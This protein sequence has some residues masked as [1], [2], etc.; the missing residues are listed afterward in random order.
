[1]SK[2]RIDLKLIIYILLT[3]A[4]GLVMKYYRG[5][6]SGFFN[7]S[8]TGAVYVTFWCFIVRLVLN[9]LSAHIIAIMVTLITCL[10]EFGQLWQP[11]FLQ[12]LRQYWIGKT[13]LGTTF[14]WDD[15]PYYFVGG[16][17]GWLFIKSHNL[18]SRKQINYLA[19]KK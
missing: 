15:L 16:F 13:L 2:I 10:L 19:K 5:S 1:M 14:R 12:Y 8:L 11:P 3:A 18:T 9:S 7:N 4:I 6:M 17:V